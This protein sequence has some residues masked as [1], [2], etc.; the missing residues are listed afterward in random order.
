MGTLQSDM[1][2]RIEH[3][4]HEAPDTVRV[5][6]SADDLP[7]SVREELKKPGVHATFRLPIQP[8]IR[9]TYS[10]L[11]DDSAAQF[12]FLVKNVRGGR[13]SRFFHSEAQAG[14]MLRMVGIGTDL[15]D[16]SW[17]SKA[18]N[19]IAFAGGIG[20]SPIYSCLY[21]AVKS[22]L[23][24]RVTL[25]QSSRS[26]RRTLLKN[27]IRQLTSEPNVAAYQWHTEGSAGLTHSTNRFNR[28][29]IQRWVA[30]QPGFESA[31]FLICG[32]FGMMEEIH[33]GLDA[34][35]IP[36]DQ[37][38]TEH[39]TSRPLSHQNQ[40]PSETARQAQRP[41][42]EVIIEQDLGTKSFVMHGEGTSILQAA[43][44]AGINVP[45]GCSGG[46]CLSCQAEV[47]DGE[48]QPL[49]ISGLTEE[50]RS[51]GMMLC[52]RA[53]PKSA[54]LRLRLTH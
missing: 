50:E 29:K 30:Q 2:V 53:Q 52:C 19:F 22:P 36:M 9:R 8:E 13:A 5:Q 42:C 46:I 20:I 45:S 39:F 33:R 31:T 51:K 17:D 37:R 12:S 4:E 40:V 7:S 28:D 1:V 41:N 43:A 15:W 25:Y 48:I 47:L 34:L 21:H 35:D 10:L 24:H 3:I 6:L 26:E 27:E 18:Q 23:P 16:D 11:T 54:T 38:F 32:P 14:D 49:G 44:Q